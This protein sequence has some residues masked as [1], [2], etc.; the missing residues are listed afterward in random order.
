MQNQKYKKRQEGMLMDYLTTN[1]T[2]WD[3]RT[4][5]HLTSDF[6]DVAG[7]LSGKTS[8]REIELC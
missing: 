1:K 4:R 6:Y 8:L 5:V 3:A 7:F 2:A